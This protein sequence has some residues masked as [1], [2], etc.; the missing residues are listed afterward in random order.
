MERSH[1]IAII[2]VIVT[3]VI[4]VFVYFS[5]YAAKTALETKNDLDQVV[6][7]ILSDIS[8]D[9]SHEAFLLHATPELKIWLEYNGWTEL[10]KYGQ[11]GKMTKYIGITDF[12]STDDDATLT[13]LANFENGDAKLI[14][15]IMNLNDHWKIHNLRITPAKDILNSAGLQKGEQK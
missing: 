12:K 4:C 10:D 7:E 1:K 5:M 15:Y 9:W 3:I 14:M 11:L 13:T 6:N 8:E 2:L